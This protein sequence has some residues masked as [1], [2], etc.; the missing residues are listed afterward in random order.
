MQVWS[1]SEDL[2]EAALARRG[3]SVRQSFDLDAI[4]IPGSR[5]QAFFFAKEKH[6]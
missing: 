6:V 1:I 4:G 5:S 2:V 3:C